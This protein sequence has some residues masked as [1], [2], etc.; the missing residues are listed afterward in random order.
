[1][2]VTQ[3][4]SSPLRYDTRHYAKPYKN[5]EDDDDDDDKLSLQ[6]MPIVIFLSTFISI[7]YHIGFM[8]WLIRKVRN[9]TCRE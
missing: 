9:S 8:T 4:T 7:L 2:R 5:D 1:M 6:A 3:T